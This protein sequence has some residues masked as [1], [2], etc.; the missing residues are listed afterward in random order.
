VLQT[1]A[2]ANFTLFVVQC[3]ATEFG[4]FDFDG[5]AEIMLLDEKQLDTTGSGN[6][7]AD[8][9]GDIGVDSPSLKRKGGVSELRDDEEFV[10]PAPSTKR[11]KTEGGGDGDGGVRKQQVSSVQTTFVSANHYVFFSLRTLI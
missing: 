8:G 10:A 7:N 9:D 2:Y 6:N 3:I 11:V 4:T 1:S 5:D